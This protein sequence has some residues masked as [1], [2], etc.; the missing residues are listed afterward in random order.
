ME[1]KQLLM[2]NKIKEIIKLLAGEDRRNDVEKMMQPYFVRCNYEEKSLTIGY[3]VAEWELNPQ[4]VMHGGMI[5]TAF[6][7]AF[8][9]LTHFFAQESFITT[10][11][12]GV[13]FHKPV[14]L[15]DK[16]EITVKA[17]HL[18]RTLAVYTGEL[19]VVN[20][21]MLLAD[22]AT[23]TFIILNGK[24]SEIFANKNNQ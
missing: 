18:G 17:N 4:G 15:G 2:E 12:L 24:T 9:I 13:H 14:F 19:R 11:E 22:S 6:D 5:T 23:T 3:D 16:I 7:N 1:D 20:R 21:D 10:V 8:G